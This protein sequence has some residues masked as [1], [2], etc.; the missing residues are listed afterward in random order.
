MLGEF[1]KRTHFPSIETLALLF[2]VH[3]HTYKMQTYY[4]RTRI[5]VTVPFIWVTTILSLQTSLR[6]RLGKTILGMYYCVYNI[7]VRH[8]ERIYNITGS[9]D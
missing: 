7:L 3:E 4:E 1:F 8:V 6:A 9:V 5:H 2:F